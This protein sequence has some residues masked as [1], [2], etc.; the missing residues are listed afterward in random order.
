MSV[1]TVRLPNDMIY[2]ARDAR[3]PIPAGRYVE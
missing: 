2:V 3:R 1:L